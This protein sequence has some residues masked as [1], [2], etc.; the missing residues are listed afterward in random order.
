MPERD[1]YEVL[2]VPPEADEAEIRRA[3][4]KIARR[5][6]PDV[7]PGDG[8]TGARFTEVARAFDVLSDP[9]R[10]RRYDEA[11]GRGDRTG[12]T[13]RWSAAEEV[14]ES[15]GGTVRR[16][17]RSVEVRRGAARSP[18][19]AAD[20]AAAAE[21]AEDR[22]AQGERAPGGGDADSSLPS[23][24]GAEAGGGGGAVTRVETV[25]DFAEAIR[26]TTCSFPLQREVR[27]P[28]CGGTGR[29]P[30]AA[31]GGAGECDRCGGRGALVELERV[32]VRLPRAI[33]DGA[34]LRIRDR[35]APL[36]PGRQSDL[37]IRVHVRPHPYFRREGADVHADLPVTL[38]EAVLGAEVE[39]PTIDGPVRV[40][41]PPATS[42]G[43]RF[44]L[45]GRGITPPGDTPGD[46]YFRVTIVLPEPIGEELRRV[47]GEG[48]RQDLRKALPMQRL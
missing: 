32:R 9:Q 44:R 35:G 31:G 42:G 21:G 2:G 22:P 16:S 1:L 25:L 14:V 12:W 27:C 43:R 7:A 24:P 15:A 45:R 6:H 41:I 17:T 4:Q 10:R 8:D 46:H 28:G 26:G 37:E 40:T 48:T 39:V 33:E 11:R 47:V 19:G 34:R 36:A 3:F 13:T 38:A 20:P 29:R 30:E 5:C 18:S 23:S